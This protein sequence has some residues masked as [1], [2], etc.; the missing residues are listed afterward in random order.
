[1]I[2]DV[3][4]FE[5]E[6]PIQ[7]TP[8]NKTPKGN[9]SM[10]GRK[11]SIELPGKTPQKNIS[12]LAKKHL[13]PAGK[14]KTAIQEF[15]GM[16]RNKAVQEEEEDDDD[17][18]DDDDFE[19]DMDDDDMD[20]ISMDNDD[21]DEDADDVDE[22]EQGLTQKQKKS[23]AKQQEK[24]VNQLKK[25]PVKGAENSKGPQ[26]PKDKTPKDERDAKSLYVGNIPKDVTMDMLKDLSPD[27]VDVTL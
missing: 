5:E 17:E 12:L 20:D 15:K 18:D 6:M 4:D 13:T 2:I 11:V 24:V 21:S 23:N 10:S 25:T 9:Q 3:L 19:L 27:I 26:T 22:E 8:Q 14:E 1:M 16:K 7:K